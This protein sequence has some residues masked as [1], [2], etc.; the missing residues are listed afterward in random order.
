MK[1]YAVFQVIINGRGKNP[2]AITTNCLELHFDMCRDIV[3]ELITA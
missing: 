3:C 1:Q 2:N